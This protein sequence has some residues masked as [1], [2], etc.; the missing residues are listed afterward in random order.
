MT[1][2]KSLFGIVVLAVLVLITLWPVSSLSAPDWAVC[3]VD[4]SQIPVVNV[5]VRESY[6]NYSAEREGHEEDLYTDE[7]GCVRFPPRYL[8][9]SI[10]KR[11]VAA[12]S[13]AS[14][15][16]HAS[17]GPHSYVMAF[18]G[19]QRGDAVRNGYMYDW[20]GSPKQMT[21]TLTLQ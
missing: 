15:G 20:R 16:V 3:V 5:L 17:F 6:Q 12:I 21:S 2:F 8:R 4:K 1:R 11:L 13:S 9:L 7:H 19:A 18:R 14:G 10:F